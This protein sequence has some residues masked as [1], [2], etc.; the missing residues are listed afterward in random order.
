MRSS[1]IFPTCVVG[2][3]IASTV[4]YLAQRKPVQA[5]R[6]A[7]VSESDTAVGLDAGTDSTRSATAKGAAGPG[8][9]ASGN[10]KAAP[11][12]PPAELSVA[13]AEGLPHVVL[14]QILF[15]FDCSQSM[16]EKIG[17][18]TKL[19]VL[20]AATRQVIAG[21]P[22]ETRVGL[23]LYGH[24]GVWLPRKENPQAERLSTEDPRLAQDTELVVPL[25][26]LTSEH[27]QRLNQWLDWTSPRGK[28]PLVHALV[29]AER[30]IDHSTVVPATVVLLS[31][32]RDNCGGQLSDL[33][34]SF[35]QA[36]QTCVHAVG[37]D[38]EDPEDAVQLKQIAK[39]CGGRFFATQGATELAAA[40]ETA[41][42]SIGFQLMNE[43]TGRLV[44][45]GTIGDAPLSL[46]PGSYRVRLMLPGSAEAPVR[47][48]S[49]AGTCLTV[50]R[51]ARWISQPVTTF[52]SA[53]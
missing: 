17:G 33:E 28:T 25:G 29:E 13:F 14:P 22:D 51:H 19:E 43:A 48:R 30:D 21:L 41:T 24:W 53:P 10:R 39:L 49:G 20:R 16:G 35:A 1:W 9:V 11:G 50:D 2:L 52:S 37:F 26:P 5:D 7:S 15:V 34:A 32:G 45:Q 44:A 12:V 3:L 6:L 38:L 23:R 40:L 47:L 27:R 31:D 46:E 18:Q 36:A 42:H 4:V 8:S